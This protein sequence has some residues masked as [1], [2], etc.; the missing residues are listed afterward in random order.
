MLAEMEVEAGKIVLR[1]DRSVGAVDDGRPIEGFAI[2]GEDR[3][4]HP[5]SADYLVVGE[6]AR[7]RP[8]LDRKALVLSSSMVTKPIHYRY[9]WARS[10]M[11]N[12]QAD[13]NSDVPFATQRSDCWCMEHVPLGVLGD[14][15]PDVADRG[16]RR[17]IQQALQQLDINR[18]LQEAKAFIEQHEK[19]VAESK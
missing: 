9:A 7:G 8:R 6:D 2:A 3:A 19:K 18:R 1:F 11:G 12:L 4:F 14:N 5:A 17:K 15:P 13:R 16:Q 10:P